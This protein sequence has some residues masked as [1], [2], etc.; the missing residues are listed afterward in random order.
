MIQADAFEYLRAQPDQSV[1]FLFT[2]PPYDFKY[3]TKLALHNE[4]IRVSRGSVLVF[5]P[6]ENQWVF[7]DISRYLFWVKPTS[8]LAPL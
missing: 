5:S 6:P 2:D 1:D 3:E 7:P 8:W 4:F